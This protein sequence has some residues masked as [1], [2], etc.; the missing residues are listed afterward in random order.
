MPLSTSGQ[1]W[2]P[3]VT[4][5]GSPRL[6]CF[7][8]AGSGASVFRRWASKASGE[9]EIVPVQPPGREERFTEPTYRQLDDMLDDLLP[10]IRP[11]LGPS[12]ALYG[13]SMG[14]LIALAVAHRLAEGDGTQPICV[15]IAGLRPPSEES[16]EHPMH[17]AS[18]H[19][20][21]E[22]IRELGGTSAA[23]L[24]NEDRLSLFLPLLR[25]DLELCA[26]YKVRNCSPL[27]CA[28]SVYGGKLD[29]PS[30][31][32]LAGWA[33]ATNGTF[34]LQ[35]LPGGHFF[36]EENERFLLT[37]IECDLALAQNPAVNLAAV[38]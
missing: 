37:A 8:S 13:H 7:P 31:A 4:G 9:I 18:D 23:V 1:R 28:L 30:A 35:M 29:R 17:L 26:T 14:G 32:D 6:F 36:P 21:R 2:L 16:P 11:R 5:P 27:T 24:D 25:A 22:F 10:I 19:V 12:F 15:I 34:R 38:R 20:L 33:G 3:E